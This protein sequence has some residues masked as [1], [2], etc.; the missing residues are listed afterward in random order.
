M[1]LTKTH[2]KED[3]FAVCI[4][5]PCALLLG[6]RQRWGYTVCPFVCRV[7]NTWHTANIMFAVCLYICRVLH[8]RHTT[9]SLFAVCP[10]KCTR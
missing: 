8:F 5:L 7:L 6:T 3:S 4:C 9:K 10:T 2:G 1:C